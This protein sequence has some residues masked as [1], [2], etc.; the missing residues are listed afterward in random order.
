MIDAQA[1]RAFPALD[2][3]EFML[4]TTFRRDGTAVGTPVWFAQVGDTLYVTTM[5]PA[6]KVKRVRANGRA[7]VAPCTARGDLLGPDAPAEGRVLTPA[8]YPPA[9]AALRA[10][11]PRLGS[12][13]DNPQPGTPLRTFVAL[14]PAAA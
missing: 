11:Y 8:E 7:V 6:G 1:P 10:K 2:G 12:M 13:I 9:E 14:R 3:A 4:L 5:E